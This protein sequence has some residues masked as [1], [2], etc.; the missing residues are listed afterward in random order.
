MM[1]VD[2]YIFG[3]SR[4][5]HCNKGD[6]VNPDIRARLVACEISKGDKNDSFFASTLP[7]EAKKFFFAQYTKERTRKGMPLRLSFV[8]VRKA[9]FNG[10]PKGEIYMNFPKEM[11]RD[12][13]QATDQSAAQIDRSKH[14]CIGP[15]ATVGHRGYAAQVAKV[16]SGR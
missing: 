11:A 15:V 6:A 2:G 12:G 5:V 7:L 13:W 16:P 10:I 1:K 8:D 4:W 3:R 14:T 9:Y